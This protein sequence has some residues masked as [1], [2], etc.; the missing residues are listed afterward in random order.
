MIAAALVERT[1]LPNWRRT[2]T[3]RSA[4]AEREHPLDVPCHRNE[5]PLAADVV[6][7]AQQELAESHHRFDDPEHRFRGLFAQG[8]EFFALRCPQTVGHGL[9]GVELANRSRQG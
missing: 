1:A 9:G 3:M 7:P 6:E 5:A 4:G 8:V 2:L